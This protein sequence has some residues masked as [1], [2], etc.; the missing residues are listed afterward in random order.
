MRTRFAVAPE[1]TQSFVRSS[2]STGDFGVFVD[3]FRKNE[4]KITHHG[5]VQIVDNSPSSCGQLPRRRD[6][7]ARHFKH[8]VAIIIYLTFG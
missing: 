3:G 6:E 7:K 2:A 8:I 1:V 4:Y 5:N